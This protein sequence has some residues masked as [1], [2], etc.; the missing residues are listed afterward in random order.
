M[1]YSKFLFFFS[2]ILVAGF[3]L[4]CQFSGQNNK[5]E[6]VIKKYNDLIA[7]EGKEVTVSGTYIKYNPVPNIRRDHIEYLSGI[8]LSEDTIP[9]LFLEMPRSDHELKNFNGKEVIVTGVFFKTM[10]VTDTSEIVS[11]YS[12]SWLYNIVRFEEIK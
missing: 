9:R 7:F 6:S 5:K 3:E 2:L 10:P 4:S 1:N 11:K 12:G 8:L